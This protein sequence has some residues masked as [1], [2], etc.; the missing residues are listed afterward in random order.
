VT[1]SLYIAT[2]VV[3]RIKCTADVNLSGNDEIRVAWGAMV[4]WYQASA[5]CVIKGNGVVNENL[6]A[7][8]FQYFGAPNNTSLTYGGN[9]TFTGVIYAP[10]AA[11]TLGGGGN[12]TFD[13][14]GSSVTFTVKMN[15]SYNFH[16]DENLT[17]VGPGRGY[18][19]VNW[20]EL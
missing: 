3:C 10:N 8:N 17:K 14:T 15:G 13:F 16:Y 18:I 20:K 7:I 1:K 11:F 5:N 6:Q 4:K 2:N 19:P 9:G 12:T